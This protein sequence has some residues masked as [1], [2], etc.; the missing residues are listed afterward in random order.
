MIMIETPKYTI[1]RNLGEI[2]IRKYP[3]MVLVKIANLKDDNAFGY[4]FRYITGSNQS[5]KNIPMTAPVITSE[6]IP[7]TTPVITNQNEMAFV[8][9]SKY[10][11]ETAPIP[12]DSNVHLEE[13]DER[14]LAVYQ[15][16]GYTRENR[17]HELQKFLMAELNKNGIQIVGSPFLMRYNSP[18]SLGFMRHN[19]VAVEIHL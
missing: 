7:M 3:P 9:P 16:S 13:V 19:E 18:F 6:K 12:T 4:L 15:F 5:K 11:I 14:L 8:L 1:V 10:S 17:V 2:E